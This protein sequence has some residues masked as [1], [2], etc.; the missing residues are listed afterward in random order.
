MKA[1]RQPGWLDFPH[2]PQKA[3]SYGPP[4]TGKEAVQ[5]Q[6]EPKES[7]GSSM[8]VGGVSVFHIWDFV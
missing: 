8:G 5:Q 4:T 7:P 6:E 3:V 2:P 1:N